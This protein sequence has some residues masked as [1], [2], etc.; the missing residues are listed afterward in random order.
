MCGQLGYDILALTET[1]DSGCLRSTKHFIT[2][3]AAPRGDPC[4]GVAMLLSD[5]IA[6]SVIHSGCCATRIVYARINASPCNLFVVC[7][8]VPHSTRQNPSQSDTLADLDYLLIKAPQHD[9]VIVLGDCNA[10]LHRNSGKQT[11]RWCIH[12]ISNTAGDMLMN[13][14]KT[15]QLCAIS[16]LHQPRRGTTNKAYLSKDPRYGPSQ[17]DS[18]LASCRW[19]S[20]AYKS[21]VK[22]G[23]TCQRWGRH[24]DHGLFSC[25]WKCRVRSN[26]VHEIAKFSAMLSAV[27]WETMFRMRSCE[28]QFIFYQTVIDQFIFYYIF[29][30]RH[31]Y[32]GQHIQNK[33][34]CFSKWPCRAFTLNFT[35][36]MLMCKS[37]I[38]YNQ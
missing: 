26:Q 28:E 14:L 9:C 30:L 8:Y 32:T 24:Y 15:R 18:I 25:V 1:H 16:T 7:V 33:S 31:I 35:Y 17:I 37:H 5:R 13:L 11:G 4:A 12:S 21:C 10:K 6:E 34:L 29:Y 36:N 20:S 27:R 2:G 38:Q 19:M 22:W 3:D 23:V